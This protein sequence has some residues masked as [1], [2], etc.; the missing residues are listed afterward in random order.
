[1]ILLALSGTVIAG[2]AIKS[3]V[4]LG[5]QFTAFLALLLGIWLTGY[6]ILL[7]NGN[8]IEVTDSE[9]ST[10][11]TATG[12]SLLPRFNKGTA[13]LEDIESVVLG[14]MGYFDKKANEFNDAKLREIIDFW[15]GIFVMK[16]SPLP[17]PL[18]I[19]LA[20]QK[21]PLLLIRTRTKTDSLVIST[22][23]FS[24]QAFRQLI[25]RLRAKRVTIHVE[26]NLL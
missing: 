9:L 22:K 14:T 21:T 23:L 8:R 12:S 20:A 5:F 3:I 26:E 13:K 6:A 2:L 11:S 1:M 15:H 19:W 24:K 7:A 4:A 17:M 10:P 16:T 18:P 25:E